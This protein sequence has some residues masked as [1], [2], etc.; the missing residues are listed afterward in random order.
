LAGS[1]VVEDARHLMMLDRP[2]LLAT[3]VGVG[4]VEGNDD[5]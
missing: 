3:A 1:L 2:D 4:A 5:E